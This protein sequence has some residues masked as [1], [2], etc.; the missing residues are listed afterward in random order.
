MLVF[1]C[2]TSTRP[3]GVLFVV[4][5]TAKANLMKLLLPKSVGFGCVVGKLVSGNGTGLVSFLNRRIPPEGTNPPI[6][7]P[8]RLWGGNVSTS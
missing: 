4:L 8:V 6:L 7:G 2:L 5:L 3:I 1:P